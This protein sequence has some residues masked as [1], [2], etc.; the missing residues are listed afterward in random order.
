MVCACALALSIS[1]LCISL[2][3]LCLPVC[4][5]VCLSVSLSVSLSVC[6]Y[7]C[8]SLSLKHTHTNY[9]YNKRSVA[10]LVENY[11]RELY[12]TYNTHYYTYTK[13]RRIT[14]T[15]MYVSFLAASCSR[16]CVLILRMLSIRVLI[17]TRML[18]IRVFIASC[19]RAYVPI[20]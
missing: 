15:P 6:L 10:G 17:A 18:S 8:L 13:R 5:P 7:V 14:R 9:T 19:S 12:Y 2:S 3:F 20:L 16:A 11:V 4:L 1:F